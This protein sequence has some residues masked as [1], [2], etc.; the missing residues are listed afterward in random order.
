MAN[1]EPF[2]SKLFWMVGLLLMLCQCQQQTTERST[3]PSVFANA[4]QAGWQRSEGLLWLNNSPFNG[5][6][7]A[8]S[9]SGD[10]T[11]VGAFYEGKAEGQHRS[12]HVN[13]KLKEVRQYKNGWQEGKQRGW[14]ESGKPAFTYHFRS[15]MYEGNRKEWL[16]SGQLVFDGNYHL[17]QEEGSQRQWFADGSLKMNYVVRSGRTYGFTG[18]KNCVNVWDSITVGH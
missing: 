1:Q 15:D 16:A 10:T 2:H 9:T 14:F 3:I 11:F 5:W 12:W 13:R 8:L 6:Q 4:N 18:V 17:G 7:F